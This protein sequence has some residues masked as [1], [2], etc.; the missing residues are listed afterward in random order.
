MTTTPARTDAVHRWFSLSYSNYLVLPRTLMQSMPAEW[1]E[2]A[3]G[4]LEEFRDA[5]AHVPQAEGYHVQAG[6]WEYTNDDEPAVE[7]TPGEDPVP[8]YNRGRTR[9]EPSLPDGAA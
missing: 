4:L 6:T 2:R 8:H 3:V 7:F 1:Q 5:F 9:I